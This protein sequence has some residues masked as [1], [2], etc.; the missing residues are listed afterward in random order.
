[1]VA[2][3]DGLRIGLGQLPN[4]RHRIINVQGATL[5]IM[6]AGTFDTSPYRKGLALTHL[7]HR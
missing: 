3:Q 7:D 1:M 4:Q 5:T 2:P 6:L